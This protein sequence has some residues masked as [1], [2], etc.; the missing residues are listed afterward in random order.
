[1]YGYS[2]VWMS[3]HHVRHR[4]LDPMDLESQM[5]LICHVGALREQSVLLITNYLF[6]TTPLSFGHINFSLAITETGYWEYV[7]SVISL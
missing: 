6:I 4:G 3:G 7:Y 5:I 2:F 1:M